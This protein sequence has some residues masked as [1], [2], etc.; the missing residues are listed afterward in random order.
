[1]GRDDSIDW[2]RVLDLR[3]T[4]KLTEV[5]NSL[6]GLSIKFLDKTFNEKKYFVN[7]EERKLC[8]LSHARAGGKDRCKKWIKDALSEAS[9]KKKAIINR[10]PAQLTQ[11]VIPIINKSKGI[12]YVVAGKVLD[13]HP[14]PDEIEHIRK[15]LG[16]DIEPSLWR[17]N[18][19]EVPVVNP[20][21]L[22]IFKGFLD[23]MV[24][25]IIFFQ[26]ELE[27]KKENIR[28]LQEEL[29]R[30][31]DFSEIIGE[32][33]EMRKICDTLERVIPSN[34]TVLLQGESGTGKELIAKI[35]HYNSPRKDKGFVA[36]NCSA[37]SENLLESELFGHEKGAFT[38]A[39]IQKKGLFELADGGTFFL[40]EIGDTS[41]A[42]QT[43]LLRV[44]Q[45][46]TFKRVGGTRFI[47]VD[48]RIIAATNKD[49]N[50]MVK[51]GT[52]REDLFYRLNEI[53]ITL[54]PLR[55][56][57]NDIPILTNFFMNK[58]CK[59]RGIEPKEIDK[60]AIECF[61]NYSWPGN[62]RELQNEIKRA[63]LLAGFDSTITKNL[64]SPNILGEVEKYSY[65]GKI[66]MKGSLK[67]VME[68]VER[69]AILEGL[70]RTKNNRSKLARELGIS[71]KGLLL[72]IAKYGL[73][74]V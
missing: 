57:K 67:Y 73:K 61:V 29:S 37:F 15:K 72:K 44:L 50:K 25:D 33:P 13:A 35:V 10:C 40:D 36:E 66:D 24:E 5:C 39:I 51:N 54:P 17:E 56:R 60:R 41:P 9:R 21:Q 14:S 28:R 19:E 43:K 52:F 30:Q 22:E 26:N 20:E 12:G 45:D 71:R 63:V 58:F 8:Q 11:I 70:I 65:S 2:E 49:I 53:G 62:V 31:Y 32:S 47:K 6:G 69:E 4:K 64:L 18:Y 3:I 55:A 23:A 7:V 34:S 1:M 48:V 42:L 68:T 27:E 16:V 46:G 38:G 74:M 59:E